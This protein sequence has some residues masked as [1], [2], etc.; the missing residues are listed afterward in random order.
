MKQ[1]PL[2]KPVQMLGAVTALWG[3]FIVL[4]AAYGG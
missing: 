2:L 3:L 1:D 4:V